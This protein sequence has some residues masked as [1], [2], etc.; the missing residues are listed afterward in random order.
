MKKKL[1]VQEMGK[2]EKRKYLSQLYN[3]Q[4]KPWLKYQ[5]KV[6]EETNF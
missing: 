3:N 1:K 5:T 2:R 4:V 6:L